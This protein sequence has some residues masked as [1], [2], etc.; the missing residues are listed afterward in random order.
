MGLGGWAT[1]FQSPSPPLARGRPPRAVHPCAG[2]PSVSRP[3]GRW[4]LAPAG[5]G[6]PLA[7]ELTS[8]RSGPPPPARPPS[9]HAPKACARAAPGEGPRGE[10]EEQDSSAQPSTLGGLGCS[11]RIWAR[12]VG[13]MC[14]ALPWEEGLP[15]GSTPRRP[16]LLQRPSWDVVG[17]SS[18]CYL[19]ASPLQPPLAG[20]PARCPPAQPGSLGR[21]R[22]PASPPLGAACR[23]SLPFIGCRPVV[24]GCS[25]FLGPLHW[26]S[27]APRI[28][29][30]SPRPLTLGCPAQRGTWPP[31]P[32]HPAALHC[33]TPR[34]RAWD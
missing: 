11:P 31:L 29:Q 18:R 16:A 25:S 17:V 9:P 28:W 33:P 8:H 4:A 10:A 6:R 23:P 32:D 34:A 22:G 24:Y 27:H 19:L 21:S 26:D 20:V 1:R 5:S 3:P 30:M 13:V 7:K 2:A 15:L 12:A 14:A